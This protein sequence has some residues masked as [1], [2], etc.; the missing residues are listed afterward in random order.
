[1]L[2]AARGPVS[3]AMEAG[4]QAGVLEGGYAY[5]G[6]SEPVE[7]TTAVSE[8]DLRQRGS[9][10][11]E[12]LQELREWLQGSLALA[13][14]DQVYVV[15]VEAAA[16]RRSETTAL[17]S[18]VVVRVLSRMEEHREHDEAIR[19]LEALAGRGAAAFA[20]SFIPIT[21]I[22]FPDS[23]EIILSSPPP[24]T[25]DPI[26][27]GPSSNSSI[28]FL[29]AGV[30]GGVAG[31]LALG[32]LARRW[33]A[34]VQAGEPF[35]RHPPSILSVFAHPAPPGPAAS[36]AVSVAVDGQTK[37]AGG[38]A[39]VVVCDQCRRSG[40][41]VCVHSSSTT[42]TS[43]RNPPRPAAL[44]AG[45]E[46]TCVVCLDRESTALVIHDDPDRTAHQVLCLECA[47]RIFEEGGSCPMCRKPI[48]E[49][50]KTA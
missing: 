47:I 45:A 44:A 32:V 12:R 24:H 23:P 41:R 31:A 30:V 49:V 21:R 15:R 20:S 11:S 26:P 6:A 17:G 22:R 42:R 7:I 36:L 1:M 34:R 38:G 13:L 50:C 27:P 25:Q 28:A 3:V 2:P 8:Q 39:G 37:E 33:R 5:T 14:L 9:S 43:S 4:G 40:F 18:R 46:K 29:L 10:G 35:L 19:I 48:L 16:A